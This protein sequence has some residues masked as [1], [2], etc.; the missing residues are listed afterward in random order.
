[1]TAPSVRSRET[2]AALPADA[3]KGRRH[4]R[5]WVALLVVAAL[6]GVVVVTVHRPSGSCRTSPVAD[7][8]VAD[9]AAFTGWL[10]DNHAQGYVGE[11]GWPSGSDAG[12]W[13]RVADRWFDAADAAGLWTTVWA[14]GRWWPRGYRMA[15]YRLAGRPGEPDRAG[16]QLAVLRKHTTVTGPLRGLAL[17]SGAFASGNDAPAGYGG[18]RPGRPGRDYYYEDSSD[19]RKLS[20]I[21]VQIVRLS[22]SWERVQ[23]APGQALDQAEV[24]RIRASLTAAGR[25]GIGVVLDLHAFGYYWAADGADRHRRLVLGSKA[26]P[27][28]A[29][30]DLWRRLSLAFADEQSLLGLGLMNE[31][32]GMAADPRTGAARWRRASQSA[33]DAIRAT[34]DRR[35]VLVS[36]YGGASTGSWRRF[37]P[38]AWIDD[39]ADAV[40]YEAHQYFDRDRS[41]HY[42]LSYSDE[43]AA[44]E[45]GSRDRCGAGPV[46]R[47]S[48]EDRNAS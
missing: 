38:T 11:V 43:L 15:T 8:G 19:Y 14:A 29:F 7:R 20:R 18:G 16:S 47:P 28:S 45:Q 22:F 37:Q 17:P 2:P 23:H 13:N 40:R 35:T 42:A 26:L 10:A 9:L 48:R 27:V 32:S 33:V 4:T 25:Y 1:M 6:T 12:A 44:A 21:G 46:S 24:R 30:A 36:G 34:G 39:P 41:G 5:R 31:P 3:G